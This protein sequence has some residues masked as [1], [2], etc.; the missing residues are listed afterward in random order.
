MANEEDGSGTR[1]NLS[2]YQPNGNGSGKYFRVNLSSAKLIITT[3]A[4]V[5]ALTAALFSATTTALR[6]AVS[7]WVGESLEKHGISHEQEKRQL[8]ATLQEIKKQVNVNGERLWELQRT[9]KVDK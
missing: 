3:I 8:D 6:P 7:E 1:S 2:V 9:I 4:A 5:L